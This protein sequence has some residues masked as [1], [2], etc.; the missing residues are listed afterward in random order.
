MCGGISHVMGF[1]LC[2]GSSVSFLGFYG[3]GVIFY[4]WSLFGLSSCFVAIVG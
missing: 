4:V 2:A 3:I 1:V